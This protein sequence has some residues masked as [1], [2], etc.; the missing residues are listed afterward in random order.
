MKILRIVSSGYEQGGVENGIVLTNDILRRN[1]HEVRVIS[2]N[3]RPDLKHYSNYEFNTVSSVWPKK[4]ISAA[5]NIDS[6][7]VTKRVLKE[8]NPDVVLLHTMSQPTASVLFALRDYPTILF[9]HGPEIFIKE[10][11]PWY[12]RKDDYRHALYKF[13]GLSFRGLLHYLYFK[14]VCASFYR[15]GLRNVNEIVSLSHYTQSILLKENISSLYIPNG[16]QTFKNNRSLP[17]KPTLLYAGRLEKFKGVDQLLYALK[18]VLKSY[19]DVTLHIAGDGDYKDRLKNIVED[20]NLDK[21]VKFLGHLNRLK[22]SKEYAKTTLLVMPSIWPETFGKV[23]IEAMSLGVPV[24]ATDVGGV[25]DWLKDG[26]NGYLVSISPNMHLDLAEKIMKVLSK[27][28]KHLTSMSRSCKK[29]AA[30]FS[31]EAFTANIETLAL[32]IAD[33]NTAKH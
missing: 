2:S 21:S 25:K 13:R 8:F 26:Q 27:G 24:V 17:K 20:L 10:L 15:L 11:L 14:Y 32:N 23:G 4:F 31:I 6:Y 30:D 19:P 22:L 16:A 7:K 33:E 3:A 5:F 28:S 1:G 12:M 29:T 18:L 9:V